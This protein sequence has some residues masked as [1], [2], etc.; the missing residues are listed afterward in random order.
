MRFYGFVLRCCVPILLLDAYMCVCVCVCIGVC[1]LLL[2]ACV[3]VGV[4]IS[5]VLRSMGVIGVA[6]CF[7]GYRCL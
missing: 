3:C 5:F 6:Y 4:H 2:D 7:D 1:V